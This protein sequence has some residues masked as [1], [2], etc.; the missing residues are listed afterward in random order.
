M[1]VSYVG[2]GSAGLV[3]G[4]TV[5]VPKPVGLQASDL[6]IMVMMIR[7]TQL[8]WPVY[9][10]WTFIRADTE[11]TH[12]STA[13]Y[14]RAAKSGEP[15]TYSFVIP[16][17]NQRT[18]V[19]I[20][21]FRSASHTPPL[22]SAAL[23]DS[24]TN[25]TTVAP[26]VT[27]GQVKSMLVA[28]F[29][30]EY[31]GDVIT[32]PASM[33][34][35]WL[36]S[37]G[38]G[39]TNAGGTVAL[40][41][42]F[43]PNAGA[44]GTRTAT[45]LQPRDDLGQ[46]LA[47]GSAVHISA[48]VSTALSTSVR[49]SRKAL[50]TSFT[51]LKF[52]SSTSMRRTRYESAVTEVTASVSSLLLSRARPVSAEAEVY[53][54][55]TSFSFLRRLV[56]ASS[57]TTTT[58][59][60]RLNLLRPFSA[61]CGAESLLEV[62]WSRYRLVEFFTEVL[63]TVGDIALSRRRP[64]NAAAANSS[65]EASFSFTRRLI[66]AKSSSST[67]SASSLNRYRPVSSSPSA[68]MA[69]FVGA[70]FKRTGRLGLSLL[71][72]K[73]SS[74]ADMRA[75]RLVSL[76]YQKSS[77]STLARVLRR[78]VFN[79]GS[80]LSVTS[81]NDHRLTRNISVSSFA[82]TGIESAVLRYKSAGAVS[83]TRVETSVSFRRYPASPINIPTAEVSTTTPNAAV[84]SNRRRGSSDPYPNTRLGDRPAPPSSDFVA[85][86]DISDNYGGI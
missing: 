9:S 16:V 84:A 5:S 65:F 58:A 31:Q 55:E 11:A 4:T 8:T 52:S 33:S 76:I 70:G 57:S 15:S 14:Y 23:P 64:F 48:S 35:A 1:P 53:L 38:P 61:A 69:S 51:S 7:Q 49:V 12:F 24:A 20:S 44:T 56:S 40:A 62:S 86:L 77:I 30:T 34:L 81:D 50:I 83:N 47:L 2:S 68:S 75:T 36:Q 22:A 60:L 73:G 25:L 18:V 85:P 78:L 43:L 19:G 6:M 59:G 42:Q 80:Q 67:T 74:Q 46:T 17:A 3:N 66:A 39:Q 10:G 29:S 32:P 82:T 71:N 27:V 13:I 28:I 54:F 21:A 37:S 79:G 72:I 41:Y 63:L 45:K 26:S